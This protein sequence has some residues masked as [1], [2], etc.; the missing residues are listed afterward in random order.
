MRVY[1]NEVSY[2]NYPI[3]LNKEISLRILWMDLENMA[4]FWFC[5]DKKEF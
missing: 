1:Y 2:A 5:D 3:F 4:S